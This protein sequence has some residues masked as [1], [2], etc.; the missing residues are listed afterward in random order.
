[1]SDYLEEIINQSDNLEK[2]R[3]LT[4]KIVEE[5]FLSA[6]KIKGLKIFHI[7]STENGGGVAEMLQTQIPLE[8]SLGIDSHWL[9][10]R[11]PEEF[12]EV[13]KKIHNILQ[14]KPGELSEREKKIYRNWVE[15]KIGPS[16]KKKIKAEKPQI[17]IIHDPQPLPLIDIVPENIFSIFRIH[18]DLS[19]PNESALNFLRPWIEKY[20]LGIFTHPAY[21]PKWWPIKKSEFI[22]PAIN[23]FSD[24][25][26]P[27]R[28]PQAE[29]IINSFE[30]NTDQ[31]IISQVSRFDPWKDQLSTI[32]SY[33]IAKNEFS[34][35]E[36]ILSGL[37]QANDDPEAIKIFKRIKKEAIGD[38]DI[39]LFSDPKR[40]KDISNDLFVNA[41]YTASQVMVQKSIR[42]GFGLVITEAMWK[43]K[44]VIGGRTLG[45]ELQ[46]EDGKN[47]FLASDAKEIAKYLTILLKDSSLRKKIGRVARETVKEKFLLSRLIL[48]HLKIYNYLKK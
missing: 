5:C 7:N 21:R 41:I 12:F 1:M 23:P 8:R 27:M 15:K 25:N 35:L 37:F 33:Y 24:K 3:S 40:L 46:I 47:G 17:V 10:M 30:I 42:E 28:L 31:P 9:V 48:E 14:G 38:P 16:L 20:H 2:Y 22:A 4:P 44:P 19:T 18:I 13:T 45:I 29:R 34:S 11:A 39:F 43:E 6:K 32:Q 26:K 36:L